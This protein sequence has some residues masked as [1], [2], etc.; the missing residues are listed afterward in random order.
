M[1]QLSCLHRQHVRHRPP[2]QDRAWVTSA[3]GR[4]AQVGSAIDCRLC[5]RAE[6]PDGLRTVRTAGP[7]SADT[8]PAGL[9]RTHRVADGTWGMLRVTQGSVSLSMEIEPPII[10]RLAAGDHQPLPPGAPHALSV[11]G[12]FQLAIDFLTGD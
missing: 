9:R 10:R 12:P 7:F 3:T 8:L 2:F 4:E 11:D 5:D 1:A 6:L